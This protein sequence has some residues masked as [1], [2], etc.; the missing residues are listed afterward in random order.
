MTREHVIC[1]LHRLAA[2]NLNTQASYC[3]PFVESAIRMSDLSGA[4][5]NV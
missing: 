3:L 5:T 2:G 4:I 1:T